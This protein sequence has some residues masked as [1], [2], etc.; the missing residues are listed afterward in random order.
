MAKIDEHSVSAMRDN[1]IALRDMSPMGASKSQ[2]RASVG[3]LRD[4]SQNFVRT[5]Q[6]AK[7]PDTPRIPAIVHLAPLPA[8]TSV[9]YLGAMELGRDMPPWGQQSIIHEAGID[10][11]QLGSGHALPDP[12]LP[13]HHARRHL[14]VPQFFGGNVFIHRSIEVTRSDVVAYVAYRSGAIHAHASD[15]HMKH[16]AKL[17]VLDELRAMNQIFARENVDY[18]LL[19]IARNLGEAPDVDRFIK[20][21]S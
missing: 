18:L 7:L 14:R 15:Y 11:I 8:T 6:F 3:F 1:L 4:V 20:A 5:W 2:V 19:S 16:P 10:L 21:T 9:I 13:G 12:N 17:G